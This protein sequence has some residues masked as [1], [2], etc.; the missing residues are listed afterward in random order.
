MGAVQFTMAL[1]AIK[2]NA[3]GQSSM[4]SHGHKM[5]IKQHEGRLEST[6]ASYPCRKY[7]TNFNT[8]LSHWDISYL[9]TSL[10]SMELNSLKFNS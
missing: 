7:Q 1:S 8:T 9:Q 4:Q 2:I 5:G 10:M 3:K 6:T